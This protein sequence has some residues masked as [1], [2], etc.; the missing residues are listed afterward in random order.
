[1]GNVKNRYYIITKMP[2]GLAGSNN[3]HFF[4]TKT[5]AREQKMNW[6]EK[7]WEE[8][9]GRKTRDSVSDP[10]FYVGVLIISYNE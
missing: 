10:A 5:R 6:R 2:M 3:K 8:K 9:G 1:M 4:W 7:F